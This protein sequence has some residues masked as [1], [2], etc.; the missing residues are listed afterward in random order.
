MLPQTVRLCRNKLRFGCLAGKHI[1]LHCTRL[2]GCICSLCSK[3]GLQRSESILFYTFDPQLKVS[4]DSGTHVKM[5]PGAAK[6]VKSGIWSPYTGS[7]N[8]KRKQTVKGLDIS[9]LL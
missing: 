8:C 6:F 5:T 7:S 3:S 9:T 2:T 1:K 4:N